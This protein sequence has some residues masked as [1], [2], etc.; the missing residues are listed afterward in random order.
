M[1]SDAGRGAPAVEQRMRTLS[2]AE[3]SLEAFP[4]EACSTEI[5]G[6]SQGRSF[7]DYQCEVPGG[8]WQL[9]LR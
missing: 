2:L 5:Q 7:Y 3:R 1:K 6:L 9:A 8:K 4:E